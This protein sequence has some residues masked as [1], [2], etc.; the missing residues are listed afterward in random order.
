MIHPTFTWRGITFAKG[1]ASNG[2]LSSDQLW[3]VSDRGPAD[4]EAIYDPDR[5]YIYESGATREAALEAARNAAIN[6][7][8]NEL[9]EL[10]SMPQ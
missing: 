1:P 2:W 6:A 8:R 3:T 5:S 9:A 7:A 10:E 4:F